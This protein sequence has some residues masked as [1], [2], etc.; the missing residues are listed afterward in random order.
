MSNNRQDGRPPSQP[1]D[2]PAASWDRQA[3][4]I[5][6]AKSATIPPTDSGSGS[7]TLSGQRVAEKLAR[8]V[9]NRLFQ[10]AGINVQNDVSF[11]IDNTVLVLDGYDAVSKIGY[12]FVS[13]ADADV[14]TDFDAAAEMALRAVD[15]QGKI[16]LFIVHD[17][18]VR[19]VGELISMA[20]EFIAGLDRTQPA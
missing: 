13:H 6:S 10:Q 20:Q 3:D 15:D 8:E 1:D 11:R 4:T 18:D 19:S 17:G 14:V 9:L 12:Q 16:R 2:S 7:I 5:S